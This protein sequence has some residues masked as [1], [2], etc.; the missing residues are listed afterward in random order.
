MISSS[1]SLHT[2]ELLFAF[3]LFESRQL[4]KLFERFEIRAH[5]PNLQRLELGGLVE[6]NISLMSLLTTHA[7]TLRSLGLAFISLETH[8]LGEEECH[9]S[10]VE[11]IVFL[12][13][14]LSLKMYV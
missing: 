9:G 4:P 3:K 2:F 10:W 13:N 11:F 5:W 6:T 8:Q 14:S 7:T 1:S 12:Q